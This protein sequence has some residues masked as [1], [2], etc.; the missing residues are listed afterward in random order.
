MSSL[1]TRLGTPR[2]IRR[3]RAK[4]H[5]AITSACARPQLRAPTMEG[6]EEL[7][8]QTHTVL[9][10]QLAIRKYTG[11]YLALLSL[12]IG[13]SPPTRWRLRAASVLVVIGLFL[14]PQAAGFAPGG[15][16]SMFRDWLPAPLILLGYHES[17]RLTLPRRDQ[18]VEK[19]LLCWG[20]CLARMGLAGFVGRHFPGWLD[21]ILEFSYLQCY[22]IV[23]SGIAMLYLAR[24]RALADQ[25]W[26]VVLSAVFVAYGLTPL[27]P[28]QPPR[29]LSQE[30]GS[31]RGLSL[32]RR[33]NLWIH[34]HAS[35]KVNTFPSWH[36]AGA[37]SASLALMRPL[38]FVGVCY[39]IIAVGIVLG[40]V[41]GRYHY[42]IDAVLGILVA[43]GAYLGSM[44]I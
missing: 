41:R 21:V 4:R 34:D 12:F 43:I 24:R 9:R 39:M 28:A 20:G 13:I 5:S 32:I 37:V 8:P 22:V 15:F 7:L 33:L 1:E 18:A 6:W 16:V 10:T 35:I 14:L 27:F 3:V 31:A 23:P 25:Y 30:V 2:N 19:T 29:R 40:S 26:Y 17:G 42:L 36:V 11:A 44:F 38:P